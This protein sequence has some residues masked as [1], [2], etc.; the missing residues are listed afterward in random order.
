MSD[1]INLTIDGKPVSVPK[2]TTILEAAK[3]VNIKI[4][5]LCEHPALERRAI[6]RVCV[7][8]ADGGS[9][10]LAA[11]ANNVWEGAN[12]VTNN[13]RLLM[14]RK[15]IVELILANHPHD[16]LSCIR[17]KTC[18]LQELAEHYGLFASSFENDAPESEPVIESDTLVRNMARCVKCNRCVEVCQNIQTIGAINTSHRS[19]DFE[20][21]TAYKQHLED[22]PCVFCGGCA[23]VCPVGAIYRHDQTRDVWTAIKNEKIK[24]ISQVSFDFLSS[25]E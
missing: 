17:N 5:V 16:C 21:S 2:G 25:L 14:I 6:C 9:K 1:N 4:P 23:I 12:I 18:E 7:V 13:Q 10:L 11:C 15:T 8:E 20:I 22:T 19:H 24:A 3:K